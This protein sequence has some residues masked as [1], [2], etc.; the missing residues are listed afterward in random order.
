MA[1]ELDDRLMEI[2]EEHQGEANAIGMG[3]LYEGVFRRR[4]QH[5]INDTSELRQMLRRLRR[6]PKGALICST[7]S[8]RRAGIPHP[9][10]D[11]RSRCAVSMIGGPCLLVKRSPWSIWRSA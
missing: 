7:S 2:L 4:Y 8:K 1:E 9:S 10:S 6:Q 11:P 3:D 5:R